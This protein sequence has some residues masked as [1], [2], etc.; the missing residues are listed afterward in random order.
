M[1]VPIAPAARPTA[2]GW[3]E[4][5]Y[6]DFLAN[7]DDEG[8]RQMFW[9]LFNKVEPEARAFPTSPD[10]WVPVIRV[11]YGVRGRVSGDWSPSGVVQL[12][13]EN[14]PGVMF[15]ELFHP[16]F[17]LSEFHPTHM[18]RDGAWSEAWCDAFRYYAEREFLPAPPSAW[19]NRIDRLMGMTQAQ[20]FAEGDGFAKRKYTY[21]ASLIVKS[22]GGPSGSIATLRGLWRRLVAM[23]SQSGAPVMDD[24]FGFAPPV[25]EGDPPPVQPVP[26]VGPAAP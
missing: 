20:I 24:F 18:D 16:A 15:H 10:R 13:P 25:H 11:E 19:V 4:L 26:H 22:L 14:D 7:A 1:A 23:R 5:P 12:K 6:G 8:R 17:H 2:N 3:P 21:P 9:S